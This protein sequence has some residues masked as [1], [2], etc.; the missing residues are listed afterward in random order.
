MLIFQNINSLSYEDKQL[1]IDRT[2]ITSK[3]ILFIKNIDTLSVAKIY[4]YLS[5]NDFIIDDNVQRYILFDDSNNN[6]FID[7][8]IELNNKD[9]YNMTSRQLAEFLTNLLFNKENLLLSEYSLTDLI[10]HIYKLYSPK[11]VANAMSMS[12]DKETM[13]KLAFNLMIKSNT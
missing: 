12:I 4:T 11:E 10:T 2:S 3:V 5:I 13:M 7:N 6:Y 1:L 9:I 8:M